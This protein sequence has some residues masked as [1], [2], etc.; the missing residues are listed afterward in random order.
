MFLHQ[1]DY[2]SAKMLRQ[3]NWIAGTIKLQI[4]NGNE[5]CKKNK[6]RKGEHTPLF[7]RLKRES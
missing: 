1:C 4:E 3:A 7:A 6:V 2:L 5:Q